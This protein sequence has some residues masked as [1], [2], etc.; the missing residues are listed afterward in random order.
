MGVIYISLTNIEKMGE[1]NTGYLLDRH[2]SN[3][4]V[5]AKDIG[6]ILTSTHPAVALSAEK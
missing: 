2:L 3:F 4:T 5:A 6:K 1:K